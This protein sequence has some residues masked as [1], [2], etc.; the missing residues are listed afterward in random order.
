MYPDPLIFPLW[1]TIGLVYNT[2]AKKQDRRLGGSKGW[3]GG[4][5]L[6][7]PFPRQ[8]RF[9]VPPSWYIKKRL[10]WNLCIG[11][12]SCI[13]LKHYSRINRNYSSLYYTYGIQPCWRKVLW[14]AC[15]T[16]QNFLTVNGLVYEGTCA[17]DVRQYA[18]K[19][20]L[21]FKAP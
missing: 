5:N 8:V 11:L 19:L 17:K 18:K 7:T 6:A 4:K 1:K 16:R 3:L 9:W 20:C 21:I 15:W 12:F 2:Q 14:E 13:F 10:M